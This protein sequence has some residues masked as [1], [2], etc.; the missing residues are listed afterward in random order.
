LDLAHALKRGDLKVVL[1][2][3]LATVRR[4]FR[5]SVVGVICTAA[6]Y[7]VFV[8]AV[9]FIH[10]EVANLIAWA[11]SVGLG[12]LLNRRVTY[13]LT[14]PEGLPRQFGLFVTGSLG[15]LLLSSTGYAVFIGGLH[16][17]PTPAFVCTTLFTA[18]YMFTY[19]ELIAFRKTRG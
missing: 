6:S 11:A 18:A 14:G 8:M 5:F 12:F 3:A 7:G 4:G 9:R 16:F 15:Q 10:F 2:M 13:R 17:K 1:R 19:L